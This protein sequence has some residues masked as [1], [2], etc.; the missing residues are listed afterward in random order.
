MFGNQ[1]SI[2][3]PI[4]LDNLKAGDML[5]ADGTVAYTHENWKY[6]V[7]QDIRGDFYFISDLG[8]NEYIAGHCDG[9]HNVLQ[10]FTIMEEGDE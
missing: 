2:R 7:W 4:S 5:I 6:V 1:M 3:S 9:E 8:N 10:G